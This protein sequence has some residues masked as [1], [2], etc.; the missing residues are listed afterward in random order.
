MR[1][2]H[3]LNIE[4]FVDDADVKCERI[5]HKYTRLF[6]IRCTSSFADFMDEFIRLVVASDMGNGRQK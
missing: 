3:C 5:V 4:N 2:G 6:R 1:Y